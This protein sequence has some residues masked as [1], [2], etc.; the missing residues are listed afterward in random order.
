MPLVT[1]TSDFGNSDH[2]VASVKAKLFSLNENIRV[3]DIAHDIPAF[4]LTQLAFVLRQSFRD[5]PQG[6]VHIVGINDNTRTLGRYLAVELEGHC[7]LLPDNGL[8]GLIAE[9]PPTSVSII[10]NEATSTFPTKDI[11][12]P[13]AILLLEGKSID[14]VGELT[15]EYKQMIIR[16]VKATRS[17]ISGHVIKVD[18][19]GNLITNIK[20]VDFDILS[21]DKGYTVHLGRET[22]NSVHQSYNDVEPGELFFVF[23]SLGTL[24]IG[25]NQG[26]ANQLMGLGYDAPV[27]IKFQ[28]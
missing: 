16:Q 2:Y 5:F 10:A 17:E 3:I 15:D 14:T 8:I 27:N 28:E 20:K 26:N 11:L 18:G 7:F 1:F 23:N 13:I 4:D 6:T 21:K 22:A 24:E 12:A 25:I 9:Q 19:Y